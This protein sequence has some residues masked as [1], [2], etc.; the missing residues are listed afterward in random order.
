MHESDFHSFTV[1]QFSL[2]LL[3]CILYRTE[4]KQIVLRAISVRLVTS[5]Q[6]K[7]KS[8]L[9]LRLVLR[10]KKSLS[11]EFILSFVLTNR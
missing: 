4:M 5:V 7:N 10:T 9:F 3:H 11:L 8:A 1:T 6:N 2:S